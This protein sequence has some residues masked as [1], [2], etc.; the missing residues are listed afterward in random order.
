MLLTWSRRFVEHLHHELAADI[1]LR[2][3]V[4]ISSTLHA[5]LIYWMGSPNGLGWTGR[6]TCWMTWA[7]SYRNGRRHLLR[8]DL[9]G[10]VIVE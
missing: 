4:V 5:W 6:V 3:I 1:Y 10:S 9:H 8:R 7:I 2:A